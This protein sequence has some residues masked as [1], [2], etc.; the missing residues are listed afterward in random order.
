M[1]YFTFLEIVLAAAGFFLSGIIFGTLR[2]SLMHVLSRLLAFL[3]KCCKKT[4]SA[5]VFRSKPKILTKKKPEKKHCTSTP[6]ELWNFFFTI[7]F[8]LV[9]LACSYLLV[10]GAFRIY[11]LLIM[12]FGLWAGEHLLGRYFARVLGRLLDAFSYVTQR[13]VFRPSQHVTK[14]IFHR[15]LRHKKREENR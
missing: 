9:Y 2:T 11:F 10:D 1:K 6:H 13:L 12:L 15:F 7:T 14:W 4:N 5:T 8:A 3:R